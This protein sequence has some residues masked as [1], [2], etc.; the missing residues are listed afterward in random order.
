MSDDLNRDICDHWAPRANLATIRA[1]LARKG[2]EPTGIS[3]EQLAPYDQLH[4]GE[5]EATRV[6]ARWAS[7]PPRGRVLDL[8]SGLGGGARYLAREHGCQVT[9]VELSAALH[10][11]GRELTRWTRLSD[12]V[13]HRCCDLRDLAD[14]AAFDLVWLQHVDMHLPDKESLYRSCAALLLPKGR[15]VWHDWLAG[16]GGAPHLPLPWTRDG[17]I[18]FLVDRSRFGELLEATCLS[19]S[20][21]D[22]IPDETHAWFSKTLEGLLHVLDRHPDHPRTAVFSHLA[23]AA[24]NVLRSVEERRLVPMFA[25]ARPA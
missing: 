4:A 18:S 17:S 16:P 21:L 2:I 1:D 8:G 6:F 24:Q 22:E 11:A 23:R 7:P 13:E 19:L 14:S 15:A 10:D 5:F 20:R 3:L 9:A 25:E 12:Q